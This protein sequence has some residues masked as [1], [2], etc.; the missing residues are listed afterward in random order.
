MLLWMSVSSMACELL[1]ILRETD[2]S[3]PVP[4]VLD[5][6]PTGGSMVQLYIPFSLA[7]LFRRID[8]SLTLLSCKFD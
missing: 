8:S 6:G 4:T 2:I 1:R 3:V 7:V 5:R